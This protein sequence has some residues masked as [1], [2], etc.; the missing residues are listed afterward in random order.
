MTG[1]DY[2]AEIKQNVLA[3][4]S[5]T[6]DG[7]QS[8][9]LTPDDWQLY[10]NARLVSLQQ[11]PKCLGD[12]Y[13]QEKERPESWWRALLEEK[14]GFV[15]LKNGVVEG[16]INIGRILAPDS[17]AAA[18]VNVWRD[19]QLRGARIGDRLMTAALE[20]ATQNKVTQI[21][22]LVF[23]GCE[24]AEKLYSRHG[25]KRER[26]KKPLPDGRRVYEMALRL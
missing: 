26:V 12:N 4:S 9:W 2:P 19:D 13:E 5:H 23:E 14:P 16:I 8:R 17:P 15:V 6:S 25:F 10:R 3:I 18:I 22:L 24:D 7:L 1:R 20:W 11:S 21:F